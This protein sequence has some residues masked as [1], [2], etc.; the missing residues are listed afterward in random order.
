MRMALVMTG[1][2]S[3]FEGPGHLGALHLAPAVTQEGEQVAVAGE[4]GTQG[5]AEMREGGPVAQEQVGRPEGP[6][7][8]DQVGRPPP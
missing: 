7:A 4:A 5:R 2:N 8:D 6:G 3:G 1:P